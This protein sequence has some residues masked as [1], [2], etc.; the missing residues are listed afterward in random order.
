MALRRAI[1]RK[2]VND[3][4]V[5]TSAWKVP[6][7][8][9][10][11]QEP[12]VLTQA[13]FARLRAELPP[14]LS[15]AAQFA[16]LTGLRMRSLLALTGDRIDTNPLQHRFRASILKRAAPELPL[17][18]DAIQVVKDLRKSAFT[19]SSPICSR[20]AMRTC[21]PASSIGDVIDGRSSDGL[22]QVP[23]SERENL[24]AVYAACKSRRD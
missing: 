13:E 9:P 17:S 14:L 11:V 7:Y 1:L 5:L 8:R 12:S 23:T 22:T 2:C 15:L 3:W 16:V 4:Q 10:K 18:P 6:M 21:R 24:Y 19:R 20:R